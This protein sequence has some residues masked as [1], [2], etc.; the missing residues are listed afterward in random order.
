MGGPGTLKPSPQLQ[1]FRA[2]GG[3]D[4]LRPLHGDGGGCQTRLGGARQIRARKL[5][6]G[7]GCH[8]GI[9]AAGGVHH[10]R[11]QDGQVH[12]LPGTVGGEH[13]V[14]A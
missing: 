8:E 14:S 7:D 1:R 6:P 3:V 11:R 10:L 12:P 13:A 5:G 4:G 9:P 2:H